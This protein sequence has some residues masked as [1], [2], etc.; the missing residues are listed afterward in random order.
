MAKKNLE[1]TLHKLD[2]EIQLNKRIIDD[3]QA[4]YA[5]VKVQKSL[6]KLEN[7][8]NQSECDVITLTRIVAEYNQLMS[9]M[10]RSNKIVKPVHLKVK[11]AN[12]TMVLLYLNNFKGCPISKDS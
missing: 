9:N 12:V 7:L 2:D 6:E 4:Y 5:I 3:K 11:N 1:D 8:L 10:A